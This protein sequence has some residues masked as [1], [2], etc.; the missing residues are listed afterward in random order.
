VPHSA[1][2]MTPES[3]EAH[4]TLKFVEAEAQET[5]VISNG[6][7]STRT[8]GVDTDHTLAKFFER[9]ILIAN[10]TWA[11]GPISLYQQFNPWSLYFQQ[12][13]VIN[14]ISNFKNLQ[15]K[16]HVKV[17][18][19]GSPFHYGRAIMGYTP[20]P[21]HDAMTK[22][23]FAQTIDIITLSQKPNI[24]LNPTTCQGGE[25]ELPFLWYF[26]ALNIV[27][28]QWSEMGVM[29]LREFCPLYHTNGSTAPVRI[30]VFAWATDVLLSGPTLRNPSTIAPQSKSEYGKPVVSY[31]ATSVASLASKF[32][33]APVIGPYA[34]ATQIG[35]SAVGAI[36]ALFGYSRPAD[37]ERKS[38]TPKTTY[39][40]AN[41][42]GEDDV[43]KL[44]VDAKQELSIDPSIMGLG[45]EDSLEILRIAQHESFL[46][47]VL[48]DP[49]QTQEAALMTCVVDPFMFRSYPEETPAETPNTELH[50]TSLAFAALPF[51]YWRGSI[52]FRFEVVCSAHHRGKLLVH[53]DPEGLSTTFE[54]LNTMYTTTIDIAET[55]D[56]E[57]CCGWSQ[58]ASWREHL[59]PDGSTTS[60]YFLNNGAPSPFYASSNVPW[61]NGQLGLYVLSQLA[62]PSVAASP[63]YIN[64]FVRAGDDFEVASPTSRYVSAMRFTSL[65]DATAPAL[66]LGEK[67]Q[68]LIGYDME[69][70]AEVLPEEQGDKYSG[71]VDKSS[72]EP[73]A[74]V[75]CLGAEFPV[76]SHMHDVH[77][78]ETVRSFRPLLK[79]YCLSEPI[80][81]G[82]VGDGASRTYHA[83]IQRPAW[84]VDVGYAALVDAGSTVPILT[85]TGSPTKYVY[86]HTTLL[87]YVSSGFV[88]WRGSIRWKVAPISTNMMKLG[89]MCSVVGRFT[90]GTILTSVSNYLT[91][92]AKPFIWF[93]SNQWDD[94]SG[95][96]GIELCS[97]DVNPVHSFEVPFLTNYRFAF[98]RRKSD[99]RATSGT[100]FTRYVQLWKY[101]LMYT[102]I[103]AVSVQ[104]SIDLATYCAAGEDFNVGM[105]IG[106][107][108]MYYDR[109]PPTPL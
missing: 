109:F 55:P 5:V 10:F 43:A 53:Y 108:V 62:T 76:S 68:N 37:L 14:R 96:S 84:P 38:R 16:L 104:R 2:D 29:T 11:V 106:P 40:M 54:A 78:G 58:P 4:Q 80:S 64:I 56:F 51:D 89:H 103:E 57:I 24:H 30:E 105:Y 41:T 6:Y 35:A 65:A 33:R 48:W 42:T 74:Q 95:L 15:A 20:L 87:R 70:L 88:A 100:A 19:N 75:D 97:W 83:V 1:L 12:S 25:M 67:D 99:F 22:D 85:G 50:L 69:P 90:P 73:Q 91:S 61:G 18:V 7:D 60:Q 107:P 8:E 63:V 81:F 23:R 44:T 101:R 28:S 46:T 32:V 47:T 21:G 36:A 102:N 92:F 17:L 49:V 45:P 27:S 98:A 77:F 93:I 31:M 3:S 79:R 52:I 39:S 13:K 72:I 34:K 66:R 9:P 82:L 94:V 71:A 86:G 59:T 26:N